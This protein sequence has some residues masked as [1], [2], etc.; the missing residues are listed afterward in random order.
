MSKELF[1]EFV[2]KNPS[3]LDKINDG[4]MTFQK[5]YEIYT[6]YGEDT[7]VWD[8]YIEKT[9]SRSEVKE[10]TKSDDSNTFSTVLNMIKS[11]DQETV[12]SGINNVQKGID[13]LS[14]FVKNDST[15]NTYA[16]R[17]HRRRYED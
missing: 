11:L 6:M 9:S 13:V 2:K 3:L 7:S 4:S 8:N 10:T 16:P 1:K 15:P 17:E 12:K 14:T 5:Y